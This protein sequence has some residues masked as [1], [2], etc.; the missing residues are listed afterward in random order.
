MT[1]SLGSAVDFVDEFDADG[2][3]TF[4]S[5]RGFQIV[6]EFRKVIWG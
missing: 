6:N 4:D 1:A 2:V 5:D 3:V